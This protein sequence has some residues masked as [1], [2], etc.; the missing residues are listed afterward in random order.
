MQQ[1][2]AK[3]IIIA[4]VIFIVTGTILFFFKGAFNWFGK[5]P[6]DVRLEKAHFK[7]YFPFAT[8]LIISIALTVIINLI[9][10]L[11]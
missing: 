3:Y 6:G 10:K 9:K 4:G 1:T 5:L 11:F 2:A 8:M 7:L